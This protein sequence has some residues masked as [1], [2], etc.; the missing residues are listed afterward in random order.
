[1]GNNKPNPRIYVKNKISLKSAKSFS[2]IS[3]LEFALRGYQIQHYRYIVA[4]HGT[5]FVPV[6]EEI[7]LAKWQ[8]KELHSKLFRTA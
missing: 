2:S 5:R 8:I 7:A 4:K 1:M 3:R 6:F